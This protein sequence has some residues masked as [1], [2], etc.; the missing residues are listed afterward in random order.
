MQSEITFFN[1]IDLSCLF[2]FSNYLIQNYVYVYIYIYIYIY[3]YSLLYRQ[4]LGKNFN[5][6]GNRDHINKTRVVAYICRYSSRP[7]IP[8]SAAATVWNVGINCPLEYLQV[9]RL[10]LMFLYFLSYYSTIVLYI[11]INK[12]WGFLPKNP[13]KKSAKYLLS[14]SMTLVRHSQAQKCLQINSKPLYW[15]VMKF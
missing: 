10:P 13:T 3:T 2:C 14:D 6:T 5:F 1:Y 11:G 4:V 12:V 9:Y 8:N 7:L 15:V